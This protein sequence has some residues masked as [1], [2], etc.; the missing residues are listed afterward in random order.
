ML[1]TISQK[2]TNKN[3]IQ[4]TVK[5]YYGDYD[6][7]SIN[8]AWFECPLNENDAKWL[9]LFYTYVAHYKASDK[10]FKINKNPIKYIENVFG[11]NFSDLLKGYDEFGELIPWDC[12]SDR[13]TTIETFSISYFN[14][15]GIEF[16]VEL[17][18]DGVIIKNIL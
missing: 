2:E 5:V 11:K 6:S 13:S 9:S 12:V 10:Q 3:K 4:I 18:I 15:N 8:S 7:V 16:E 1:K 14:E 17:D